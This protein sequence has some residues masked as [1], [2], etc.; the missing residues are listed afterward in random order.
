MKNLFF[1]L[2]LLFS[3]T[4]TSVSYAEWT[5]TAEEKVSGD[6]YYVDFERIRKADGYHYFWM[7]VDLVKPDEYGDLSIKN[8]RQVDCKSFR[9]KDLQFEGFK[10][11]MGAGSGKS[12]EI[13]EKWYY[14]NPNSVN[15]IVLN[16]VCKI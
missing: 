1:I 13:E 12:Y 14:P 15:E 4:I 8:Y 10:A 9:F 3:L 16:Y 5:L 2:T 11:S 7:L 6:S